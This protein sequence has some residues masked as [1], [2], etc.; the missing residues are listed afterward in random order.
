MNAT[1]AFRVVFIYIPACLAMD[2][3]YRLDKWWHEPRAAEKQVKRKPAK[4]TTVTAPT[5]LKKA[6]TKFDYWDR[7]AI[8]RMLVIEMINRKLSYTEFVPTS[9]SSDSAT[10][11]VL[12]VDEKEDHRYYLSLAFS[13]CQETFYLTAS[14]HKR[15]DSRLHEGCTVYPFTQELARCWE[16]ASCEVTEKYYRFYLTRQFK[17]I[18]FITFPRRSQQ[19]WSQVWEGFQE[20]L[21]EIYY[22]NVVLARKLFDNACQ[23]PRVLGNIV[24]S[25][26]NDF[27]LPTTFNFVIE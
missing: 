18:E 13:C 21:D 24:F 16:V 3:V 7:E 22:E 26:C 15:G 19:P 8:F 2:A 20:D 23:L 1:D 4:V 12:E 9:T 5:T 10:E 6:N 25:Y 17:G 11:L 27:E 14:C